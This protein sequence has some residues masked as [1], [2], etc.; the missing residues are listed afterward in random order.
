MNLENLLS[1]KRSAILQRW[2]DLILETYPADTA[3]FL[4]E[5]KNQF[6]NPVGHI[7]LQG[8]DGFYE[9][10]LKG[11]DFKS[12]SLFLDNI[13][14]IRAVQDFT[15]SQAISFIFLLKKV[16]REELERE[17]SEN[18]LSESLLL[19][20]SRIDKLALLSF[21]IYTKCREKIYELKVNELKNSMSRLL[22]RANLIYEIQEQEQDL[23]GNDITNFK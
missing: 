10:L 3:N 9:E 22:Q 14:R 17:V 11:D 21:D 12:I 20:E 1:Q 13:I 23:K 2:Y 5:Q 7:I 16:I 8:V 19:F 6:A 18:Q 15:P 4:R